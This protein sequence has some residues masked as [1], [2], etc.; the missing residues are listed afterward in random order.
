MKNKTLILDYSKWRCGGNNAKENKLGSGETSLLNSEGFMCCLGQWSLQ[1]DK[2]LTKKEI[3]EHGA[4]SRISLTKKIPLLT[5][6]DEGGNIDTAFSNRAIHIND[7]Y[8][9]TPDQ[10]ISA[11]RRLMKKWKYKL[12]VINKK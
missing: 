2:N 11:L 12:K 4:P 7:G 9:T 5:K 3:K 1:L 6:K 10:K 8:E